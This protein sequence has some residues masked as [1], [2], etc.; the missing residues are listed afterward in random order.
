[1]DKVFRDRV[2]AGQKLAKKLEYLKG[3]DLIVVAIPRGGVVVGGEVAR[4]LKVPLELI[5]PRK[6]GAPGNPEL[7]IGAVISPNEVVINES[8]KRS[9]NVSDEYL[10]EVIEEE[11]KEIERRE[12][13]YFGKHQPLEIQGKVLVLVDD[14]LATGYT[15]LATIRALRKKKPKEI[16]LAVPVAPKETISFLSK[17][18]DEIICLETPTFFYAVGQFYDDFSQTTDEEV[19]EIL[20]K[21]KKEAED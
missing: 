5:I 17:E 20:K 21:Y 18:T 12:K 15:A 7:A 14:G 9:L 16:I 2:D 4:L 13:K 8:L 19:I 11:T 6:I 3:K 1:M 10:K